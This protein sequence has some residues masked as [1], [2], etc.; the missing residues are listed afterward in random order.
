M[1]KL[2]VPDNLAA[3]RLDVALATILP[4]HSRAQAQKLI[5]QG[6]VSLNDRKA[7]AS[8]R[9]RAGDLLVYSLAG[10]E[11][12]KIN[13]PAPD[14]PV[15]D[16]TADYIIINKPAGLV[17][18]GPEAHGAATAADILKKKFPEIARVG[19][20]P[21]RP[22]I[23]HRLDKE[24]SGLVVVARR[25]EIFDY[26]KKQFQERQVRKEYLGLVHG[27]IAKDEGEISFPLARARTRGKIAARPESGQSQTAANRPARTSFT[28]EKKY[29]H[30]TLLKIIIRTGRTHQ[31]R[32]H[33]AAFGHPLLGDDLYGTAR[34]RRLNKKIGLSRVFLVS[35]RLAFQIKENDWR[36]YQIS[37]PPELADCLKKL[38]PKPDDAR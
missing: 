9:L 10:T 31:I 1:I 37:L 19:D 17:M 34:T 3:K 36:E 29:Y 18:H 11:A 5:K 20:D 33:L 12:E 15:L 25:A 26:L 7:A 32:A 6:F 35:Q 24:V 38:K 14:L 13:H 23:V 16:A 22:G 8:C 27:N 30:Y 28:V 21:A 2:I 4:G